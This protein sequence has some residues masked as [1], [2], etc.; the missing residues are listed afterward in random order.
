MQGK[1]VANIDHTKITSV[2]SLHMSDKDLRSAVYY[3]DR[4]F[5]HSSEQYELTAQAVNNEILKNPLTLICGESAVGKTSFAEALVRKFG[6]AAKKVPI[7]ELIP[8]IINIADE[9]ALENEDRIKNLCDFIAKLPQQILIFDQL[10]VPIKYNLTEEIDYKALFIQALQQVSST[11]PDKHFVLVGRPEIIER[12]TLQAIP[13]FALQPINWKELPYVLENYAKYYLEN[14]YITPT[15]KAI[16]DNTSL[17]LCLCENTLLINILFKTLHEQ[18]GLENIQHT[19]IYTVDSIFDKYWQSLSLNSTEENFIMAQVNELYTNGELTFT[20]ET[21]DSQVL[22]KKLVRSD[23]L[24]ENPEAH[25][26]EFMH[27]ELLYY[28]ACKNLLTNSTLADGLKKA[29]TQALCLHTDCANKWPFLSLWEHVFEK[30][31]EKV[32][33][34]GSYA[35]DP[36][37][38]S[39]LQSHPFGDSRLTP[40]DNSILETFF[41]EE[42]TTIGIDENMVIEQIPEIKYRIKEFF[43]YRADDNKV[44][45]YANTEKIKAANLSKE[46]TE[47]LLQ[48]SQQVK[49]LNEKNNKAARDTSIAM[50]LQ[51]L[52]ED[53]ETFDSIVLLIEKYLAVDPYKGSGRYSYLLAASKLAEE[54]TTEDE[55]IIV[56]FKIMNYISENCFISSEILPWFQVLIRLLSKI[57]PIGSKKINNE[58]VG[59]LSLAGA[60]LRPISLLEHLVPKLIFLNT[61]DHIQFWEKVLATSN[62]TN[63]QSYAS[64]RL[65]EL[66][67][68]TSDPLEEAIQNINF[69]RS[70]MDNYNST[71]K[72]L[73]LAEQ[74][75]KVIEQ[76]GKSLKL[77]DNASIYAAW[78]QTIKYGL[79]QL[80]RYTETYALDLFKTM[81]C[82]LLAMDDTHP[83]KQELKTICTQLI[84]DLDDAHELCNGG[85]LLDAIEIS[86][87][88]DTLQDT[89]LSILEQGKSYLLFMDRSQQRRMVNSKLFFPQYDEYKNILGKIFID[90]DAD[91][92]VLKNTIANFNDVIDI[93]GK[94]CP[95]PIL[96]QINSIFI[97]EQKLIYLYAMYAKQIPQTRQSLEVI[98]KNVLHLLENMSEPELAEKTMLQ[99]LALDIMERLHL[100]L[101]A[102]KNSVANIPNFFR[103]AVAQHRPLDE[104]K[105][106]IYAYSDL[107]HYDLRVKHTLRWKL[108]TQGLTENTFNYVLKCLAEQRFDPEEQDQSFEAFYFTAYAQNPQVYSEKMLLAY[109]LLAKNQIMK[110]DLYA[111]PELRYC[112]QYIERLLT[113]DGLKKDSTLTNSMLNR[114]EAIYHQDYALESISSAFA[115][116]INTLKDQ[117]LL[118]DALEYIKG[119]FDNNLLGAEGLAALELF[120][121][122]KDHK[123][124]QIVCKAMW[125][126]CPLIE[127]RATPL[128]T[129]VKNEIMQLGTFVSLVKELWVGF[130][131]GTM[132][133]KA[134]NIAAKVLKRLK[135]PLFGNSPLVHLYVIYQLY[136][137]AKANSPLQKKDQLISK[138]FNKL[139]EK[140]QWSIEAQQGVLTTLS[141]TTDDPGILTLID[142]LINSNNLSNR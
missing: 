74:V 94:D 64:N 8:R 82:I 83:E 99:E 41:E 51:E 91:I 16:M 17:V 142:I 95:E 32:R 6:E 107:I 103:N 71:D 29:Y 13:C 58:L 85:Y 4:I 33:D 61:E 133:T 117:V 125:I 48:I 129:E 65:L 56:F 139:S 121:P 98:F 90:V 92:L 118:R 59:S 128:G 88:T 78:L 38:F 113:T 21:P 15:I 138:F 68:K 109:N 97:V 114:L 100:S 55:K 31:I 35:E 106:K 72:N 132:T 116:K 11:V 87:E 96:D 75:Q 70:T 69:I 49:E 123:H 46:S 131:L 102:A 60:S 14:K 36:A 5:K 3:P 140:D 110:P 28:L 22:C 84:Q 136:L 30:L 130:P 47:K 89:L 1:Q 19:E 86:N 77:P 79:A 80:S 120:D 54:I 43:H 134:T 57:S 53:L 141:K 50:S 23:I 126:L 101:A 62:N 42:N 12:Y 119:V 20:A 104:A 26:Y 2:T 108:Q 115:N 81:G 40:E 52:P 124:F 66:R 45:L 111:D 73:L 34:S 67:P 10:E 105:F 76:F 39:F 44:Y 135:T 137:V 63:I 37:A 24:N 93:L 127:K 9:N 122:A 27:E 18:H 25:T 7:N 112:L